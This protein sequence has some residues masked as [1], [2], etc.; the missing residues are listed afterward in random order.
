MAT[1]PRAT[2]LVPEGW[3]RHDRESLVELVAP[4]ADL[5]ARH[6]RSARGAGRPGRRRRRLGRLSRQGDPCLQAR[7]AAAGPRRLGRAEAIVNTRLRPPST[8]PSP[9]TRIARGQAWTVAII[10]GSSGTRGEAPRPASN[11][12]PAEP[13]AGRTR[14]GELLGPR[15]SS[16]GPAAG[17]RAPGL[18]P[19]V[20]AATLGVPGVGARAHRSR[21]DRLRRRGGRA[22]DGPARAG[23]RAHAL[24]GG[25]QHQGHGHAAAGAAGGPRASWTG[26]IRSPRSIPRSGWADDETTRQVLVRHLVSAFTGLP[27]K[28]YEWL[29]T[30]TAETPPRNH[31]RPARRHP[32]DQPVRRGLP[33]QQPDGRGR[34][35]CRRA[36]SLIPT[37]SWARPSM[38]RCRS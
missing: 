21:R 15:R 32:A 37:A 11:A 23:R 2:F 35:L 17:G 19:G 31:L 6:R 33:V 16:A 1:N 38:R 5:Q 14:A 28:D 20:A 34:R 36:T 27:R 7:N 24:H 8:G 13:A 22:R 3:S 30:T 18:R 29:F 12:D 25:L 4:E 9:R 26:T 10:D